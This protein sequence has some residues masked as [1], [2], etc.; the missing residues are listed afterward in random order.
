MHDAM[1]ASQRRAANEVLKGHGVKWRFPGK[2]VR[3]RGMTGGDAV[4]FLSVDEGVWTAA[5]ASAE[6]EPRAPAAR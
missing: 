6:G 2:D 1:S 3:L 5:S 4:R